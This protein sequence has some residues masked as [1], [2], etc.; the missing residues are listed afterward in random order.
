MAGCPAMRTSAAKGNSAVYRCENRTNV[1]CDQV[2]TDECSN[3]AFGSSACLMCGRL[4]LREERLRMTPQ[5]EEAM[6][7]LRLGTQELN[8]LIRRSVNRP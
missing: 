3:Q 5:L 4:R 6:K 7:I 1:G 2:E 8:A